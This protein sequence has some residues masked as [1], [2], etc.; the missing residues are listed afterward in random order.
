MSIEAGTKFLGLSSE[1]DTT[2]RRSAQINKKSEHYTIEDLT[3]HISLEVQNS[4]EPVDADTIVSQFDPENY[5]TIRDGVIG[6][7]STIIQV[8]TFD[9]NA[10]SNF[11]II[12]KNNHSLFSVV[13]VFLWD[14]TESKWTSTL[15]YATYPNKPAVVSAVRSVAGTYSAF[16][17]TFFVEYEPSGGDVIIKISAYDSS[18]V[19]LDNTSSV[20]CGLYIDV[21][22]Y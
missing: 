16:G 7:K 9:T 11:S 18:G 17:V 19:A 22:T 10:A 8:P 4:I 13:P 20:V 15:S 12:G 6:Y 3:S 5:D 1:V 21:R 14:G 2:E